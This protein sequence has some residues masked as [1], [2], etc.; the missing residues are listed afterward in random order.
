MTHRLSYCRGALAGV[1]L[2]LC[3]GMYLT[4]QMFADKIPP[5]DN[6]VGKMQDK[7]K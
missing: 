7:L 2:G 3:L 5:N 6:Y 4:S 1:F